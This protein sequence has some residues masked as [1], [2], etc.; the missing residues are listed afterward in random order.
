M[1]DIETGDR[2]PARYG[3]LEGLLGLSL[4][5]LSVVV[6]VQVGLRYLVDQPLA[7]T[8]EA[9]RF[10]FIWACML[11]A[12]VACKRGTQF[13]VDYFIRKSTGRAGRLYRLV[14][15]LIELSY[16]GVLTWAG[17]LITLVAVD[18]RLPISRV[19]MSYAYIALPLATGLMC[20][21]T[22]GRTWRELSHKAT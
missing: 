22:L 17:V 19:S 12:A 18:Q 20:L 7:W 10:L 15:K 11:G 6:V 16:Y 21:F 1:Q 3:V 8:E 5:L 9:A 4:A 2:L 13:G 14:L